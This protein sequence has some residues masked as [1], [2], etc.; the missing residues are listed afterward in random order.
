MFWP[1]CVANAS[2]DLTQCWK[3][4]VLGAQAGGSPTGAAF[5]LS[6]FLQF[7]SAQAPLLPTYDSL[8]K[9]PWEARIC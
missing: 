7:D 3:R 6:S 8:T 9:P 5:P 4:D 2:S 1:S